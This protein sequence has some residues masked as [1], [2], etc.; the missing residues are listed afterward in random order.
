MTRVVRTS[1][2]R[3]WPCAHGKRGPRPLEPFTQRCKYCSVQ[4]LQ[5]ER[6]AED[7]RRP[8]RLV[9]S[10]SCVCVCVC[11]CGCSS[12]CVC[13]YICVCLCGYSSVCVCVCVCVSLWVQLCVCVS[14]WVQLCVCV[15]A[16]VCVCVFVGAAFLFSRIWERLCGRSLLVVQNLGTSLSS[17]LIN[18]TIEVF[19]SFDVIHKYG[20]RCLGKTKL[21]KT[22]HFLF[23][24][25]TAMF[26]FSNIY[27]IFILY[28]NDVIVFQGDS[29]KVRGIPG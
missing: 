14:L 27:Q 19:L 12:V 15:C 2:N 6:F 22:L 29:P 4:T 1:S 11:L 21:F 3:V 20:G 8:A 16:C 17:S 28:T 24:T 18:R 26:P 10:L 23:H 5:S 9:Q 7:V 13:L 25:T